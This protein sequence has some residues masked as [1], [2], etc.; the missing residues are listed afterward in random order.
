M[1]LQR[2][3][4]LRGRSPEPLRAIAGRHCW[5]SG[6]GQAQSVAEST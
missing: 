1:P 5:S 6:D 3:D 2:I 4:V